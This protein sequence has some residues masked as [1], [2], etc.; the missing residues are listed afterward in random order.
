[1]LVFLS[2]TKNRKPTL[3]EDKREAE[4]EVRASLHRATHDQM[5]ER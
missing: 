3:M 1:M 4:A 5:K 2:A